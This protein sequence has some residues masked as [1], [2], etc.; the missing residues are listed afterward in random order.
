[1]AG[2][3]NWSGRLVAEPAAWRFVR[4]E[5]DAAACV[6]EAA[7]SGTP[8]RAVGASHS[9]A[10]LVPTDGL[11]VDLSGLCGVVDCDSRTRRAR[12][13]AGTPIYALG[14]PLHDAGLALENQGDIDRQTL[15]GATATGTHGTG[16]RLGSLSSRVVGAR[17]ALATGEIVDCDSDRHPELFRAARLHLGA[18]GLVTQLVL[19][20]RPA[21]RL[22]ERAWLEPLGELLP[23]VPELCERHRHFEFF[24]FPQNDQAFAKVS[25][26]TDDPAEYPLASEGQRCAWSY[27]VLAN[28][29]P[30]PHVEMEYSVPAA[31]GPD[32]LR[33]V[34]ER[35]RR[36]FPD[37]AWP[38]EY[39]RVAADDVWLSPA[40]ERDVATL[41]V[42][43]A[44][45]LDESDCFRACE[46]VFLRH[47]GRPHWG[48]LHGLD[49]TGLAAR[50]PAWPRWWSARDA[51]D[52]QGLFLN[53]TLRAWREG[54]AGSSSEGTAPGSAGAS[55]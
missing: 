2:W 19:Q 15:A 50:H 14:R 53:P 37:L 28:H 32:C 35:L 39:R 25:D 1:M 45:E 7:Q 51:C 46:E 12:I 18:L 48:K 54:G 30:D 34:A 47:G 31:A 41:S 9:H 24:W 17:I 16:A 49:G 22:R 21:Y 10:A 4:S 44:A 55:C 11:L 5:T 36:D 26:E 38:V 29:R 52:P 43:Q 23:R 27:E 20:L 40:F 6:A 13:W 33:E 8:L 42:H 3:R